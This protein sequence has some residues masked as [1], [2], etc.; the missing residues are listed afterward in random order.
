MKPKTRKLSFTI[1]RS[2]GKGLGTGTL[3]PI[4]RSVCT[5][6]SLTAQLDGTSVVSVIRS[7]RPPAHVLGIFEK[8]TL[9]LEQRVVKWRTWKTASYMNIFSSY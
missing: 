7:L 5:L 4:T 6:G 3:S 1:V 2:A 9:L 8:S